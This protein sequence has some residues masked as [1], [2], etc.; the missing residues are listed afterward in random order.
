MEEV[1]HKIDRTSFEDL[2][3]GSNL[4]VLLISV[5]ENYN[6][7]SPLL[8]ELLMNRISSLERDLTEKGAVVSFL[9]K[10]KNEPDISSAQLKKLSLKLLKQQ[11]LRKHNPDLI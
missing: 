9:L 6:V 11:K 4:E 10:Q 3:M 1:V 7:N 2:E 5:N 8:L